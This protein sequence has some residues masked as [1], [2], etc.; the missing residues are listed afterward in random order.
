MKKALSFILVVVFMFSFAS[1][2]VSAKG[3]SHNCGVYEAAVVKSSHSGSDFGYLIRLAFVQKLVDSTN[4][5]IENLVQRAMNEQ[6]PDI[7]KLVAKTEALA[8]ITIN[9]SAKLGIEVVCEYKAYEINGQIVYI[10]PLIV[11]KR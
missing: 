1:V 8:A 6:N 9:I 5:R 7:D 10:D 2:A 11:I 4:M 3:A